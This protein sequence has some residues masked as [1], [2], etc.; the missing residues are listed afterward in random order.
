MR[1][2]VGDALLGDVEDLALGHVEGLDHVVGLAVGELGDVAGDVDQL[3]QQ[4]RLLDDLGVVA[5]ARDRRRGVLQLVQRLG[6]TDL[7][8]QAGP[9][10]LVGDGDR[11]GRGARR[12]QRPDGVEDVAVG[13]LVEVGR[14]ERHLAD[15]A[16]RLTR[17]QQGAEHRLLGLDVVRRDPPA[18]RR[19]PRSVVACVVDSRRRSIGKYSSPG[20]DVPPCPK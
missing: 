8:Q 9:A 19:L 18:R 2:R 20:M 15:H 10:Q 11:V 16:D 5:G 4:R 1:V 7:G 6:P 17:Q 12:V 14:A 3:A 13:R